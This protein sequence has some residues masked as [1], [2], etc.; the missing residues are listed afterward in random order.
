MYLPWVLCGFN[1]IISGGGMMELI[2]ILVGNLY[3]FLK[4]KYPQEYDGPEFLNTPKIIEH[5]FPPQRINIRGF[6]SNV[7]RPGQTPPV[8]RNMFGG[9]SWGQGHVLGQ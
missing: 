4:F 7:P 3:F 6:T 2:G 1:L 5:Y 9:H 8:N